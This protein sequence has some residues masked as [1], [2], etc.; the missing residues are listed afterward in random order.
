MKVYTTILGV[1][2]ITVQP[3]TS[4]RSGKPVRD[5]VIETTG[6]TVI[7]RLVGENRDDL[8]VS[9]ASSEGTSSPSGKSEP[10]RG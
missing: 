9:F 3:G 6:G 4:D 10:V 1:A 5:V 7:L 8:Q 2:G